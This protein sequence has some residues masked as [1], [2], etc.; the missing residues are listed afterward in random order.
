[1]LLF[2]ASFVAGFLTVLAPC[3]FPLLPVIIAGGSGAKTN[4]NVLVLIGSLSLSVIAFTL[5]LRTSAQFIN[6]P[7]SFWTTLSGIILIIF[8]LTLIFPDIWTKI[9]E[10]MNGSS[11]KLLEKASH[12]K[13]AKR[14]ALM[15]L[16]LGPVFTSCSPTFAIIIAIVLPA[17]YVQGVFYLTVYTAGLALA[18]LLIALLGRAFT[19][20]L[21]F[22]ANPNG[23]FKK[24]MGILLVLVGLAIIFGWDKDFEAWII[25]QGY[26][27]VTT[28]EEN[29]AEQLK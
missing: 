22:A 7:Q 12:Q 2:L 29:L 11:K 16:A 23:W 4:K 27:G 6:V 19:A 20:K 17:S 24:S 5:L 10:S 28:F 15:G 13:G 1:M 21:R 3:V 18:L 25:D 26:F 8:S 9:S 14:E